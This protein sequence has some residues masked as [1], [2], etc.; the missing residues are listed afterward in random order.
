[1]GNDLSSCS[2]DRS[3]PSS[4]IPEEKEPAPR[5][6]SF[7]GGFIC[8][9]E[10]YSMDVKLIATIKDLPLLGIDPLENL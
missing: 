4:A 2:K 9:D 7:H 10:V 6:G 5:E 1:M 3:V 8:L